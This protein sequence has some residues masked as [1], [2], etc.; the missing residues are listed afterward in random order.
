MSQIQ[1][2]HQDPLLVLKVKEAAGLLGIGVN[3]AYAAIARGE[4]PHIRIGRNI[5]VPR[6]ALERL[7]TCEEE[8]ASGH[9]GQISQLRS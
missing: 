6:A 1:T 5:R 2:K 3:S 9:K 4:L 7:L 8:T